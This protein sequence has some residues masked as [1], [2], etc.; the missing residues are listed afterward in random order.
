VKGVGYSGLLMTFVCASYGFAQGNMDASAVRIDTKL[1]PYR[2]FWLFPQ[3]GIDLEINFSVDGQT[4]P[5]STL[6]FKCD[7]LSNGQRTGGMSSSLSKNEFKPS[8]IGQLVA[9]RL[10]EHMPGPDVTGAVCHVV[11]VTK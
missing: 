2:E 10:I 11:D 3:S 1:T 6:K 7:F 5:F 9:Q 4:T 8:A